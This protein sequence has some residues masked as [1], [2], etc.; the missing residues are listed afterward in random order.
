MDASSLINADKKLT[1]SQ[2]L[3]INNVSVNFALA[4][5]RK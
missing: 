3:G 5:Y 4:M 2:N 1:A